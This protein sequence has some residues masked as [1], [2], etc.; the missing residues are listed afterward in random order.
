[1]NSNKRISGKFGKAETI[2]LLAI[3]LLAAVFVVLLA[4]SLKEIFK[5]DL[6]E[7]L[8][9]ASDYQRIISYKEYANLTEYANSDF[10]LPKSE[11]ER[12]TEKAGKALGRY[13][14]NKLMQKAW[15]AVGDASEAAFYEQLAEEYKAQTGEYITETDNVDLYVEKEL[16]SH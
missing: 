10:I 6:S 12:E 16:I 14:Y 13:H 11:Q 7:D 4:S 15:E 1:M 3:I 8:Y 2:L 5:N 9:T